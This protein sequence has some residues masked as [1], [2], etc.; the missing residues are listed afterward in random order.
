MMF[1][2]AL[3]AVLAMFFSALT[4]ATS[5]FLSA[6]RAVTT[7]FFLAFMAFLAEAFATKPPQFLLNKYYW[8]SRL[9]NKSGLRP[10]FIPQVQ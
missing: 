4:A 3:T 5:I 10:F 2:S 7:I 9:K 8:D 1:F 6:L